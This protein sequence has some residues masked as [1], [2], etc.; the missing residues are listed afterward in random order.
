MLPKL[1][2]EQRQAVAAQ[3]GVPARV[4]DEQ[5]NAVYVLLPAEQYERIKALFE[6]DPL[7]ENERRIILEG[8]W[9]RANWDDPAM[10]DYAALDPRKTP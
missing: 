10:E 3:T 8:V 5:I 2:D 6:E 7:T 1:T 9:R 4:I